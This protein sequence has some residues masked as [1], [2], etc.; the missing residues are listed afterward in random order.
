[1]LRLAVRDR[2]ACPLLPTG[3]GPSGGPRGSC[4]R[5]L[6]RSPGKNKAYVTVGNTQLK[7][8]HKLPSHP[9]MRYQGLGPDYY[10]RRRSQTR[11]KTAYHVSEL[12]ELGLEVTLCRPAPAQDDPEP[13]QAARLARHLSRRRK[14]PPAAA[15]RPDQVLFLG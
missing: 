5:E 7:V 2:R 11:P 3:A 13:T 10:Q 8:Y 4:Y 9:G 14:P 12:E 15:A 6:A 1:L